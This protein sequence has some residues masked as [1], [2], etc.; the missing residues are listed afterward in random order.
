MGGVIHCLYKEKVVS[1]AAPNY[2]QSLHPHKDQIEQSD[3]QGSFL[4]PF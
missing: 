2:Q 1:G 4:K 3:Y